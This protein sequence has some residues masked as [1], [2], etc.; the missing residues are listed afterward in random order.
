MNKS[1]PIA[2]VLALVATSAAL[3]MLWIRGNLESSPPS[4]DAAA[5]KQAPRETTDTL[6]SHEVLLA[7]DERTSPESR[8]VARTPNVSVPKK[9]SESVSASSPAEELADATLIVRCVAKPT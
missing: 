4:I 7:G 3:F 9:E 8:T 1:R 5:E 2:V 6:A